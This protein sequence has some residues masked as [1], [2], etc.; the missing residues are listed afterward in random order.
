MLNINETIFILKINFKTDENNKLFWQISKNLR[1]TEY[2]NDIFGVTQNYKNKQK[3]IKTKNKNCR[4]SI[5]D[6][7]I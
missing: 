4:N 6:E 2:L 3:Q 7:V 5:R 1:K